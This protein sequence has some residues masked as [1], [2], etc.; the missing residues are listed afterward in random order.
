MP[1]KLVL[2]I[3]WYGRHEIILRIAFVDTVTPC[4]PRS[5]MDLTYYIWTTL[6]YYC[7]NYTIV[8]LPRKS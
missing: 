6:E 7:D 4:G 2:S 5:N 1:G 8:V 3:L